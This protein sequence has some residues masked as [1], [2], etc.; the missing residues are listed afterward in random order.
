M[1]ERTFEQAVRQVL[2]RLG[3]G[4][5]VTYGEVAAEAGW[6]GA[7][8]A[9]GTLLARSGGTLPWWRVVTANGRLI[10]HD[11]DE[12]ARRLAAEGVAC[13]NGRVVIGADPG[14]RRP[15]G[16]RRPPR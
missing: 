16:E 4:D 14:H 9:V 2:D 1:S 7:A 5:V 15:G 13:R 12:H 10:P 11:P 6:P 8:R 3:P